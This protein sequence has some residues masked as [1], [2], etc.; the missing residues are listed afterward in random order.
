MAKR[1]IDDIDIEAERQGA[2]VVKHNKTICKPFGLGKTITKQRKMHAD[3]EAFIER[4]TIK[5]SFSR[6][7]QTGTRSF[8]SSRD[9]YI[10][11]R[12]FDVENVPCRDFWK[13]SQMTRIRL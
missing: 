1:V 3:G 9:L 13:Y 7:W 11:T 4:K 5:Q 8:G 12:T 6:L 2:A 10:R